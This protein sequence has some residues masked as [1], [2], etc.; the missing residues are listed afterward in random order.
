MF[1]FFILFLFLF[2]YYD[3]FCVCNHTILFVYHCITLYF[4]FILSPHFII[5]IIL[6]LF[7][8]CLLYTYGVQCATSHIGM[9]FLT[10]VRFSHHFYLFIYFFFMMYFL[11][12]F[13]QEQFIY[14]MTTYIFFFLFDY[15]FFFFFIMLFFLF[16]CVCRNS[17][18]SVNRQNALLNK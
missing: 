11:C 6:I 16:V 3:Q 1:V 17:K 10:H 5:L 7:L 14:C 9:C 4:L 13:Y 8:F 18:L 2:D 15:S 12:T